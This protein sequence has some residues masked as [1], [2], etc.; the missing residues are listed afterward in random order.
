MAVARVDIERV[1]RHTYGRGAIDFADKPGLPASSRV[2]V[3]FDVAATRR[4]LV[5]AIAC[6][7]RVK[8]GGV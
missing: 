4:A 5:D 1:G 2:D 8:T 7:H 3:G 6:A